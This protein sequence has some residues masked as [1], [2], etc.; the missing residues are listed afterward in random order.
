MATSH[1]GL[2]VAVDVEAIRVLAAD[3]RRVSPA[4]WAAT[5]A[6]L[7][8]GGE[9]VLKDA[10]ANASF[11]SRIPSSGVVQ[12]SPSGGVRVRFGGDG[13]PDAAPIENKGKGHVKH[14]VFGNRSVW[15]NKNSPPAFLSPAVNKN[16]V[17]ILAIVERTVGDR[18]VKIVEG[19]Y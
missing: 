11:S 10:Q 5:K 1:S 18:V 9:L 7:A 12:V 4:A 2:P 17:Q 6:G 13:A 3:L 14:P 16:R 15:T 8:K 19:G